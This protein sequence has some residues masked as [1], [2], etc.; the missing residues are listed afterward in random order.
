M[1]EEKYSEEFKNAIIE[2][3]KG[4]ELSLNQIYKKY[5]VS[6]RLVRKLMKE[7]NIKREYK[8]KVYSVEFENQIIDELKRDKLT[9]TVIAKK[10]NVHISYIQTL[11]KKNNI[12]RTRLHYDNNEDLIIKDLQD[13]I[14]T[15][16]EIANKY[17]VTL[18]AI[19]AFIKNN[20]IEKTR[21]CHRGNKKY[22]EENIVLIIEELKNSSLT[23]QEIADKFNV[24]KTFIRKIEIDNNVVRTYKAKNA[25]VSQEI[26]NQI[27]EELKNDDLTI[28]QIADKFGVGMT[29]VKRLRKE[30]NIERHHKYVATDETKEK[31]S[32]ISSQSAKKRIAE[33][34][35]T[36]YTK[37]QVLTAIDMLKNGKGM[38]ETSE[39]TTVTLK[40]LYHIK[41][42]KICEEL[43]KD[44]VF[45][46]LKNKEITDEIL[47]NIKNDL[48]ANELTMKEIARK[49]KLSTDKIR[50]IKK[51]NN[52]ERTQIYREQ[53]MD[54]NKKEEQ[55]E[56]LIK[57]KY[58]EEQINKVIEMLLEQKT[59][60]QIAKETNVSENV[61]RN[62]KN[63]KTWLSITKDIEF[64]KGFKFSCKNC[65]T[66]FIS[67]NTKT[68]YCSTKCKSAYERS[69]KARTLTCECCGKEFISCY[70]KTR[71]CS[72]SCA[73]KVAAKKTGFGTTIR[74]K[75]VW[76]KGMKN[77]FND[78]TLK[79]LSDSISL[80]IIEGRKSQEFR[81]NGGHRADLNN[82]YFRSN[83][84]ANFARILE[85]NNIKYEYEKHRFFLES[86]QRY[87]VP[88]FYLPDTDTWIEI[89][90]YWIEDAK[91][92]FEFFKKENPDKNIK[93]IDKKPYKELEEKYKKILANWE[94]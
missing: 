17:N 26:K 91:D 87:Y 29:L 32:A 6:E 59:I 24:S 75:T 9:D 40:D 90:G 12:E 74:P 76:N 27:I 56:K 52:I 73:S 58:T 61:V 47:E 67:N 14:L 53:K 8:Y 42:R 46:V 82:Q 80:S 15:N 62:V 28:Q 34:F 79:K 71:F 31:L 21:N 50:Q 10:F 5:N 77:C 55:N 65:G 19:T 83:W 44:I 60:Q 1:S 43:T 51:E 37:E 22:S 11:K 64:P 41:N 81:G 88:D 38:K 89:K 13:G 63:K 72:T 35:D 30:N 85:Y 93:L 36:K 49:Y 69:L 33:K 70:E 45:P 92:K 48:I 94:E 25:K 78:E 66:E 20:G 57:Q 7:N 23:I 54:K 86:M 18:H 2:D 84:E 68:M 4:N 3:L 16:A 39:A